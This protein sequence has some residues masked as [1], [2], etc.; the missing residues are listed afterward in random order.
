MKLDASTI[1]FA[2]GFVSFTSGFF[3]FL[4]WFQTREDKAAL[5]WGAA[6]CGL[7]IGIGVLALYDF[8]RTATLAA[9]GPLFLGL[10][11]AG[12]W[13][14]ARIFNHGSIAWRA[15]VVVIAVVIAAPVAMGGALGNDRLAAMSGVAISTALQIAAALEFWR[16]RRERLRGRWPMISLL[17]LRALALFLLAIENCFLESSLESPKVG[18]FGIIYFVTLIYGGGSAVC[19]VTMLKDR[20]EIKHKAV[21]LID[22]LTGIANRRAFMDRAQRIIDRNLHDDT[23]FSLL[24]FDLDQFKTINDTFG[25]PTGDHVLRVFA[26]VLSRTARPA[27]VAGRIGGEEFLLALPG[28]SHDAAVVVARR[29]HEAFQNDANFVNG[30][31]VGATVSVGVATASEHGVALAEIIANA[32]GA[33]YSAKEAGRNQVVSAALICPRPLRAIVSRIA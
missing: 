3:L 28:C 12:I 11:D 30:Q 23:P 29:I 24:A 33:L 21:A 7:G 17:G 6:N 13:C 22:P 16:T 8:R 31:P 26:D 18:W 25:H 1:L 14:A 9:I 32:D 20:S 19:L 10:S 2:G 4:H 15:V 27:D 5:T